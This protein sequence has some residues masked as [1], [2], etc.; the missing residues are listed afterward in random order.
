MAYRSFEELEV[1][2]KACKLA[3]RVYDVLKDSRDYGLKDQMTRAA[4]SIASNIAEGSERDSDAEFVR[5][6]NIAKGSGAELRTQVYIACR[7]GVLTE[8]IQKEITA[9]L[10]R[11]SSMRVPSSKKLSSLRETISY[12]IGTLADYSC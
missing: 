8:E 1:W 9:D 6:L 10:K 2:Q 12:I 7:I 3:V 11:I 4:V 5:F